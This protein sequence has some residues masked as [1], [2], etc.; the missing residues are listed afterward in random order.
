MAITTHTQTLDLS[1]TSRAYVRVTDGDDNDAAGFVQ[2]TGGGPVEV[3]QATPDADE[4]PDETT[5]GNILQP[6]EGW[7]PS[8]HDG[9]LFARSTAST[10]ARL[11]WTPPAA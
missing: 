3:V 10:A 2:N 6:G 5:R 7:D 8:Q 4:V 1:G 11:T 9:V